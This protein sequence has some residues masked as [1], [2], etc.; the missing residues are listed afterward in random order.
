MHQSSPGQLFHQACQLAKAYGL[1]IVEKPGRYLIYRHLDHKN[2]Y[3]AEAKSE[4]NLL[5]RIKR[6]APSTTARRAAC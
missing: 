5:A 3:L 6:L 1:F 4:A 2:I